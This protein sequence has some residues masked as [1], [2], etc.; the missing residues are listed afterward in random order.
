MPLTAAAAS[1]GCNRM[2]RP[3]RMARPRWTGSRARPMHQA[4]RTCRV[5]PASFTQATRPA[6]GSPSAWGMASSRAQSGLVSPTVEM[7]GL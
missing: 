2:A 7:P 4:P 6:R 5:H 1:S 3:A